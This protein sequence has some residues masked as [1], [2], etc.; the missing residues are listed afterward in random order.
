MKVNMLTGVNME[1]K[2]GIRERAL[3]RSIQLAKP[4]NMLFNFRIL[5]FPIPN[6]HLSHMVSP[7]QEVGNYIL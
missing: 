7:V 6:T 3:N 5:G 1:T 2:G 4:T